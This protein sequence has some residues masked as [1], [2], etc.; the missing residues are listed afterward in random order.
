MRRGGNAG[1]T[2]GKKKT[3]EHNRTLSIPLRMEVIPGQKNRITV[4]RIKLKF[5][6][7]IY[8]TVRKQPLKIVKVRNKRK[9]GEITLRLKHARHEIR[10]LAIMISP[11]SILFECLFRVSETHFN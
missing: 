8:K 7:I 3:R 11:N 2:R 4:I 9:R 5:T 1:S 6:R 10:P